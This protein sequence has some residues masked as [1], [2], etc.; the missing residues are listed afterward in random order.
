MVYN[1]LKARNLKVW[2]DLVNMRG[3]ITDSMAGGI[4]ASLVFVPILSLAYQESEN[5]MLE[6]RYAKDRKKKIVPVRLLTKNEE[7]A[8]AGTAF[9]ITAGL[10]YAD[11]ADKQYGSAEWN[12]EIDL[13]EREI[14]EKR[15]LALAHK[16]KLSSIRRTSLNDSSLVTWI[17]PLDVSADMEMYR[18]AYVP[19]TRLWALENLHVWLQN[20]NADKV[21][22]LNG[23]AGLGKSMIAW[24]I[25]QHLPIGY[26][27]GSVFFCRHDNADKNSAK[28]LVNTMIYTLSEKFPI[29]KAFVDE[30]RM[31]DQRSVAN[32]KP[33]ILKS[34]QL[35]FTEIVVAGLKK[36]NSALSPNILLIIDALDECGKAGDPDRIAILEIL[37]RDSK[38]L[39]SFVRILVTGRPDID[40]Y[41]T[42][43]YIK[44]DML[45]PTSIENKNDID[46]YI[47]HQLRKYF[48]KEYVM[49]EKML[50]QCS[51]EILEKSEGVFIFARIVMDLLETVPAENILSEISSFGDGLDNMYLHALK[52]SRVNSEEFRIVIGFILGLNELMTQDSIALF[53]DIDPSYVG[54]V[55]AKIRSVLII[56]PQTDFVSLIH[57]SFADFLVDP[58]RCKDPKYLINLADIDEIILR[59]SLKVMNTSLKRDYTGITMNKLPEKIKPSEWS[60]LYNP[61]LSYACR[62]WTKHLSGD[63]INA[64]HIST[65]LDEFVLVHLGHWTEALILLETYDQIKP[66]V[67][68]VLTVIE[69]AKEGSTELV[70]S[71]FSDFLKLCDSQSVPFVYNPLHIYQ[72]GFPFI[73]SKS[74]LARVYGN[75]E[76]VPKVLLG[77]ND[78][79]V[80]RKDWIR[81]DK[82][83][84]APYT[85]HWDNVN[86]VAISIDGRYLASCSNDM[87]VKIW[88]FVDGSTYDLVKTLEGHFSHIYFVSFSPD[89][90]KLASGSF[91]HTIKIWSFEIQNFG[92]LVAT[93]S[94]HS[95][96]VSSC[97]F[98]PDSKIIVSTSWDRTIR[99]WDA[100][101]YLLI[102]TI[103]KGHTDGINSVQFSPDG[104]LFATSS[105]DQTVRLW[106]FKNGDAKLTMTINGFEDC[107]HMVRWSSDGHL[108]AAAT[109]DGH[110]KIWNISEAEPKLLSVLHGKSPVLSLCFSIDG[111]TLASTS[112]NSVNI[113]Q[114]NKLDKNPFLVLDEHFEHVTF[115][116]FH[117][118]TLVTASVDKSM[119]IWSI[120]QDSQTYKLVATI[121]G[122]AYSVRP[123]CISADGCYLA[124]SGSDPKFKIWSLSKHNTLLHSIYG[125][126]KG[127]SAL[128]FSPNSK[129]LASAS[130]DCT[131]KIW[132]LD[133]I[134]LSTL[135]NHT[136]YATA[137][138]FSPD[139]SV[140]A[141]GCGDGTVKIW[142]TATFSLIYT[143]SPSMTAKGVQ[144]LLFSENGNVLRVSDIQ[145]LHTFWNS[146]SWTKYNRDTDDLF[147]KDASKELVFNS[148]SGWIEKHDKRCMWL[149]AEY[150]SQ[151]AIREQISQGEYIAFNT[152]LGQK[153]F[154]IRVND[155]IF[156]I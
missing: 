40:I 95:D 136:G 93:L 117:G 101:E 72:S 30:F 10:I 75:Y 96:G 53:M 50:I 34:P 105:W 148:N 82:L 85:G 33:S 142:E 35:A 139:S 52:K 17:D 80:D 122:H 138:A 65:L 13:L 67:D 132:N 6:I 109:N 39:P 137:L 87:T 22:W 60:H 5:C 28:R 129:L 126:L 21:L 59:L 48:P 73:P 78:E 130:Y 86:C 47:R 153:V 144:F 55:L 98:S 102:T 88:S 141:T 120:N 155:A 151:F 66:M 23:S 94:G 31:E 111:K 57:K 112:G 99:L 150:R 12:K 110:V 37:R 58:N 81:R 91:D 36:L 38:N 123:I 149:P 147:H 29:F 127:I 108:V 145:K 18:E 69:T 8:A 103:A 9:A 1:D 56:D 70:T 27:L 146:A 43:A 24:L 63:N 41:E 7:D 90:K 79:W 133:G 44:S 113:W 124:S 42:M 14:I 71:L 115:V 89:G 74:S 45:L 84:A 114:L 131:V 62:Y 106:S 77:L 68:S 32:G 49:S 46:I 121:D 19:K 107:V 54:G 64:E 100:Q 20:P 116:L 92:E 83:N 11:F 3:D 118:K 16:A 2:F 134:E 154:A 76:N 125:H 97:Q 156:E 104:K 51:S 25:S 152:L 119:K 15:S 61:V 143:I 128:C 26:V 4:D 140:L 135:S